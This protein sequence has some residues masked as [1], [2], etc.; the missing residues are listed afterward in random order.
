MLCRYRNYTDI[1]SAKEEEEINRERIIKE[2]AFSILAAREDELTQIRDGELTSKRKPKPTA[3]T[4]K[5]AF[6]Q[7][8][9]MFYDKPR[10]KVHQCSQ[11]QFTSELF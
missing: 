9:K 5:V 11:Q 2:N 6:L 7:Y 8:M 10:P 1:L 4:K 3:R